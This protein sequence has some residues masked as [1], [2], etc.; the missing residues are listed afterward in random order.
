MAEKGV[1]LERRSKK[2]VL[3]RWSRWAEINLGALK[4]NLKALKRLLAPGVAVLPVVKSE[5][6]GHG[7]LPVARALADEGVWGFGVSEVYDGL[8]LREASFTCPVLLLSGFEPHWV[9]DILRLKLTPVVTDL[10]Q[11]ELLAQQVRQAERKVAIHLKVNTGMNRFGLDA[12]DLPRALALL[13]ET[14][15]LE[16]E[17][18]M[19]HLACSERPEDPLTKE[20]LACFSKLAEEVQQAGFRPRL[21]HLANSGGVIFLPEAHF[22][23]VRPGVALY[24]AYPAEA[25]SSRLKLRPVMSFWSRVLALRQV[26]S[27]AAVGYGPLYRAKAPRTLA[28]VPVGYEDGYLRALSNRGFAVI[29]GQQVPVVGAVSMKCLTL[30]VTEVQGVKPG[31]KVLLL[32][33]AKR[34]VPPEELAQRAGTISYE[35]FCA[36]GSRAIKVY[37]D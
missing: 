35:L 31:D 29:K 27:G 33:G 16:L 13:K 11:L 1:K 34:E 14:P 22:E 26:R 6:Y 30:D 24:G 19:S 8:R 18:F 4:D 37:K 3:I 10:A 23:M 12:K 17:G 21:R 2:E 25:A 7:L 5:A 32:G 28:L 15:A 20:Q 9:A 36:L